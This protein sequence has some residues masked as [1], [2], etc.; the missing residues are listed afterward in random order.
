[1]ERTAVFSGRSAE[2]GEEESGREWRRL[3]WPDV[4]G[5]DDHH[6][7]DRQSITACCDYLDSGK[8]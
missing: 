2:E 1:M 6:A 4:A 8:L 7:R 5:Q 3:R